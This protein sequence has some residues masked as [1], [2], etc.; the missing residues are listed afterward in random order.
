MNRADA[1]TEPAGRLL[2]TER[3]PGT[4]CFR[5]IERVGTGR[6]PSTE[7]DVA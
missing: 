1:D 6:G 7:S 5:R 3:D 2:L 4:V